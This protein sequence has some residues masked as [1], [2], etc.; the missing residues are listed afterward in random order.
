VDARPTADLAQQP[1]LTNS[2]SILI[3]QDSKLALVGT[4]DEG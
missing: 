3:E 1:K 2:D 4:Y